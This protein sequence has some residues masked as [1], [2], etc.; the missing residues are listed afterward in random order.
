MIASVIIQLLLSLNLSF[1]T[2]P[3]FSSDLQNQ[4]ET[5]EKGIENDSGGGR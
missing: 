2:P 5:V 4:A 3:E 1:A